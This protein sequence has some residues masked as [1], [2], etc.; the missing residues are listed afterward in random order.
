M[1]FGNRNIYLRFFFQFSISS[2]FKKYHPSRN[3]KFTYLG[4]FQSLKLRIFMKK[5]LWISLKLNFTPNNLGRYGLMYWDFDQGG[6]QEVLHVTLKSGQI[7]Y[8]LYLIKRNPLTPRQGYA[9]RVAHVQSS[10]TKR[11]EL[12][13][14]RGGW[15]TQSISA[16]HLTDFFKAVIS[17]LAIIQPEFAERD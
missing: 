5:I 8:R 3:L 10:L 1:P 2:H 4:I 15:D 16:A 13:A 14:G 11:R 9:I 17:R 7:Q 6:T 12:L